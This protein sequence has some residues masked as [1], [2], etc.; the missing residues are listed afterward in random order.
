MDDFSADDARR[1]SANAAPRS[2]SE[3]VEQC[4][5][6]ARSRAKD[7]HREATTFL[8]TGGLSTEEIE[9]VRATLQSRG[10]TVELSPVSPTQLGIVLRWT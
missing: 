7:G 6:T 1:I 9:Q 2:V 5:G 10:F 4:L 8:A 3:C